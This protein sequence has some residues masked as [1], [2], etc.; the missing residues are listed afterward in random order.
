MSITDWSI[1]HRLTVYVLIVLILVSGVGAYSTLPRES[2]PEIEIPLI[3]VYTPYQGVSPADMETLVTRPLETELKGVAGIKEIRS[4]SSEGLSVIEVEFNP[5]IDIDTALQKVR[6]R[7]DLAKSELPPD[8]DDPRV[9]DVDL[10]QVPVLIV[11]LAGDIGLVQ[12]KEI[13][14]DLKDV[15][16]AIPGVNRAQVVGGREREVHVFVNPRRLSGYEL[17]LAD[18]V[19]AVGRENVTVPGGEIDVGGLKYL[20]RV[21]AEIERP[22]EIEDFVVKVKDGA[23]IKIRDV[24]TVVYGFEDETTRARLDGHP[25][26]SL[27]IEKRSGTN[28]IGVADA[29]KTELDH[30]RTKLP[31]GVE[32]TIVGDQSQDIRTVV[33]ELENNIIA[34]LLLV[35]AVLMAF[36]GLRNSLFV[37]VAIPLSMLM[38]VTVVQLLGYTLNMVVLFSL[39]LVLGMLVDNAIVIVE[40]IYRHREMGADGETAASHATTEVVRPVVAS[41]ITTCVAF[42]PMLFWPGIIGDFMSYLP[43]TVIIGLIASL[44]VA[45]VFNPALCAALMTAPPRKTAATEDGRFLRRYRQILAWLLEVAPDHGQKGWFLRNWLLMGVFSALLTGGSTL[46]LLAFSLPGAPP[47][48]MAAAGYSLLIGA[49]AFA[50]QG[51]IWLGWSM[52]RPLTARGSYLTDRRSAVLWSMG[53]ILVGT[54]L[55]YG[56]FGRGV[57]F[58]P[59]Q[60]PGEIWID[61]EVP[62][63]SGLDTSDRIVGEVERRTTQTPDME[64]AIANVGTRG[65]STQDISFGAGS[66]GTRSRVTLDLAEHRDRTANSLETVDEVR[67][68]LAGIHGADIKVDR[69]QNGPPT[70]K[71]VTVRVI[72]DDFKALGALSRR[73]QDDIRNI[74]GLVN[75]DDDYDEGK[76]ELRVMIDRVE[77]SIVGVDTG[78]IASTIQTAVRGVEASKYRVGEEEYDIQVRLPAASRAAIDSLSDLTV[79]DEDGVPIP[80]STVARLETGVGP[81]AVRRVDLKRVV[82]IEGDVVR[83]PGRTED[84]VRAAVAQRLD[85]MTWSAG[86]R[87]EYAGS[88]EEEDKSQEF[89]QRAFVVA[90]LLIGLV[91]VTEFN[92]LILPLTV[93]V[94]VVL[95]LIGVM[96]GLLLTGNAFGIVMTGIGVISLAGIVV[97]NAIVLCD[98]IVRLRAEGVEK[99]QAVVEAGAIR[100]RPVLLTA[101]TTVLG[102]IPLTTGINIDFFHAAI[103]VGAESAQWWGPMGVAVIF[104]LTVATALTLIVV[105]IT[106]H[107]LDEAV[108]LASALPARWRAYRNTEPRTPNRDPEGERA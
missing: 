84:T 87:W 106:Y 90:V 94:S 13:A 63:G 71:P 92:S 58:F 34:G 93:M 47:A 45:L 18:V 9:Q 10:S 6:E 78:V 65:I 75:L 40:N 43:M 105:P 32:V 49:A 26:V 96:W 37:A 39:I 97:N 35:V 100:L 3:L 56:R 54:T 89:L 59:E 14:E 68:A 19:V 102:L 104:G 55:V 1:Q 46:A 8:I 79:P 74:P 73:I 72:G 80:L 99:A 60:E 83:A 29:V 25:A 88:N 95:S 62:S 22:E 81:A 85:A 108:V 5:D 82:T 41:T 70:G 42:A 27:S 16:E 76:P 69:P 30:L 31:A 24:A 107:T 51:V 4:T 66:V 77:A 44:V 33:S 50:I 23:P 2:F 12:L 36:L 101:L 11:S 17:S 28:I 38:T 98:F 64:A 20:V 7:V 67:A 91:L 61:I 57:E 53:A 21:P 15:L 52:L 86:Y 103:E 48:I